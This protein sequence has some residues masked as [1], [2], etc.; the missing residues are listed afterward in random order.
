[1]SP[2]RAIAAAALVLPLAAAG[3]EPRFDHRDTYGPVLETLVAR[4][5]VSASGIPSTSAWRPALRLG[6][7]FDV[8]GEGGELIL[9]ADLPLQGD[10]PERDGVRYAASARYRGYFGTEELKT[11]F[12][13][14]AYV[15][16]TP[17]LAGGPLVGLGLIYDFS[18]RGGV[19]AGTEFA[20]SLGEARVFT[21]AFLAGAQ[22]RFE[23][24]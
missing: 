22:L 2:L 13:V 1:V 19:F 3:L 20:T 23:L 10:D 17:N 11:F 12:E 15:P 18:R 6:W 9:S 5:T 24:P 7:G 14:G 4:D 8:T 16:I 21:L